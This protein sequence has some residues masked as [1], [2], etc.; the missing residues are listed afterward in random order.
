ML[1]WRTAAPPPPPRQ[2]SAA[3]PDQGGRGGTSVVK[4]TEVP[5]VSD[6]RTSSVLQVEAKLYRFFYRCG[7]KKRRLAL[8]IFPPFRPSALCRADLSVSASAVA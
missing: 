1:L 2:I 7:T 4:R 8:V 6:R 5:G 3:A